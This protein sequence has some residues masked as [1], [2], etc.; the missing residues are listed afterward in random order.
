[1]QRERREGQEYTT[2]IHVR[3][4]SNALKIKAL[5]THQDSLILSR[6]GLAASQ[7]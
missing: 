6:A 3:L 5:L 7:Q 2:A 1:M 4:H